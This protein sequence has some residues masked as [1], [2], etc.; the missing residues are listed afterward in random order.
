MLFSLGS[1]AF[2]FQEGSQKAGLV[3]LSPMA[4]VTNY[5]KLSGLNNT[6]LLSYG[7]GCPKSKIL[8]TELN[9]GVGRAVFLGGGSR[10]F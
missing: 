6:N 5:H 7:F 2:P 1:V 3:Y 4:A 10:D 9:Q 8:L